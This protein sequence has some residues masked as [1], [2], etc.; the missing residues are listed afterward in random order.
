MSLIRSVE[1]NTNR[2]AAFKQGTFERFK[3]LRQ[4]LDGTQGELGNQ[5]AEAEAR[6]IA[7][8]QQ[9]QLEMDAKAEARVQRVE[10]QLAC[11]IQAHADAQ[12]ESQKLIPKQ[13]SVPTAVALGTTSQILDSVK[14]LPSH[15][16]EIVAKT[17]HTASAVR[18]DLGGET[19]I[20]PANSS[21]AGSGPPS[22]PPPRGGKGRGLDAN[23]GGKG[24]GLEAE[25]RVQ[26]VEEQLASMG[27]TSIPEAPSEPSRT[28]LL[29]PKNVTHR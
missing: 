19:P 28:T 29:L 25:A 7:A 4:Q 2:Q 14:D 15:T 22:L 17:V 5:I 21:V 1:E 9:H 11:M 23:S 24:G 12:Q 27:A 26:R 3:R 10:Q 20:Q 18:T 16:A 13:K 8:I 6:I